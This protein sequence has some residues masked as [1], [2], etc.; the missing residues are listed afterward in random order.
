MKTTISSLDNT[1]PIYM[2]EENREELFERIYEEHKNKDYWS[3]YKN[4]ENFFKWY[5]SSELL[6]DY[7]LG[8]TWL[9]DSAYSKIIRAVKREYVEWVK[10]KGYELPNII[11]LSSFTCKHCSVILD[12]LN[13]LEMRNP[14]SSH[15]YQFYCGITVED[16]KYCPICGAKVNE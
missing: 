8:K 12:N 5:I 9:A 10:D 15:N 14:T 2:D 3:A 6:E 16:I 13:R 4:N 11:D 1:Q 7:C